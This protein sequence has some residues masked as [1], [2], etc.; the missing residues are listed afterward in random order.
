MP[1]RTELEFDLHAKQL[2]GGVS[3]QDDH[4]KFPGQVRSATNVDFRLDKGIVRRPGSR[5]VRTIT[6][7]TAG[8]NY[9]LHDIYRD[10]SEQYLILYGEGTLRI[11]D[12][13]GVEST[14]S[15]STEAQA[16][17]D[18]NSA[19]ADQMRLLTVADYTF[20]VNTTVE[21]GTTIT[22]DYTVSSERETYTRL[23][24]H[25]PE[26]GTYHRVI[27][28]TDNFPAGY[29]KYDVAGGTFGTGTYA[30]VSGATW[31]TPG[32]NWDNA[33][34]KYGFKIRQRRRQSTS[35]SA[36]LTWN[37][38]TKRLT[39]PTAIWAEYAFIPGDELEVTAGTGFM[40]GTLF[41]ATTYAYK[42]AA[43]ISSTELELDDSVS[44]ANTNDVGVD[45]IGNEYE[46]IYDPP[47]TPY[48]SMHDVA[49]ALQQSLDTAGAFD[50][51]CEW[52]DTGYQAGYFVLT[53]K[54][55]GAG[56]KI[57]RVFAPSAGITDLTAA[58]APFVNSTALYT[59][60][61][62]PGAGI[63]R[64]RSI[65]VNERW[66]QVAAPNQEGGKLDP[67]TMPIK[68][69][70]TGAAT[71]DVDVV[72]WTD[73]VTG[74][75]VS[76]PAPRLF[77][78]GKTISSAFY[79]KGR[80]GF[81][82]GEYIAQSSA[83]DLLNFYL[84]DA[85][86]VNDDDRIDIEVAGDKVSN[87]TRAKTYRNVVSVLTSGG[88]QFELSGAQSYTPSTASITKSTSHFS[89]D[90]QPVSINGLLMFLAGDGQNT[91]LIE[92]L[93]DDST[94]S[95]SGS[96]NTAHVPGYLPGLCKTMVVHEN[97]R[98]V[99]VIGYDA[100]IMYAYR[101]FISGIEKQ[102]SSWS[103]W[104]MTSG[105]NNNIVDISVVANDM[106]L[107]MRRGSFYVLNR[108]PM[109]DYSEISSPYEPHGDNII[110][111]TGSHSA[112]TTTWTL[113]HSYSDTSL[114]VGVLG[115][116][117]VS[118]VPGTVITLTAN[119]TTCTA[120]GDYSAGTVYIMRPFTSQVE[121]SRPYA[122][123]QSGQ[124]DTTT[125]LLCKR[126]TVSYM[127]PYKPFIMQ[128]TRADVAGTLSFTH[129][130]QRHSLD[131]KWVVPIMGDMDRI[132]ITLAN[133]G[134]YPFVVSGIQ[135]QCEPM[136]NLR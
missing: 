118:P 35:P 102:Q 95:V 28:D 47:T 125:G 55:R 105:S 90:V 70:R 67:A 81:A 62:T 94:A 85:P 1:I 100:G 120:S 37:N 135:Y 24:A 88:E 127:S 121:F 126:F 14:V 17:I 98:R 107:L 65:P 5:Y 20:L 30:A 11:F 114:T 42:I 77:T 57:I 115:N 92:T 131:N 59:N 10:A 54:W 132:R 21:V 29:Y 33:G 22:D 134:A 96:D 84:H 113:P 52:V 8:R 129:P 51:L 75:N 133:S 6:G 123:D 38:V 46:V 13:A 44:I 73:R 80:L 26:D 130:G 36:N 34:T 43:K 16:Y 49:A 58:G 31:A 60:G 89:L 86:T 68:I 93:Y 122:R 45:G 27:K 50:T 74:T 72:D 112:G 104:V 71:F 64:K 117:F 116:S 63:G 66:S 41:D 15:I 83:N 39:S 19:D 9:R 124:P 106:Y 2:A 32:G 101:Q 25:T 91:Q 103:Q 87:I 18:A 23:I 108:V 128:L 40:S 119:G 110:A 111:L 12:L 53:C 3:Y 136:E 109:T 61:V 97:S 76:N 78:E 4:L 99:F 48:A 79:F 82:G 56:S 7:L 69:V